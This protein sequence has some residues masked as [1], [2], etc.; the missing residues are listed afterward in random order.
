MKKYCLKNN[1]MKKTVL[2]G[3]LVFLFAQCN[4]VKKNN[5]HYD[6]LIPIEKLQEDID[7]TYKKLQQLH[8]NLYD[9]ITKPALDYKFDSLK[10]TITNPMKP[11]DFYKKISPIVAAVRQGHLYVYAPMILMTKKESKALLKKG[12]GPF[13]QF[14]FEYHNNKL[15]ILNNKSTD[16]TIQVG[17]EVIC[18]NGINTSDLVAE[19]SNYYASDGFN[20]TFKTRGN[21]DR[22][23]TF[24]TIEN[25]IKDSLV[26][27]LK[28]NDTIKNR[29]I[30][31]FKKETDEKKK[32]EVTKPKKIAIDHQKEKELRRKK[33]INGYN[34]ATKDYTRNIHFVEK[35]SSIAVIKIRGFKNRGYKKFYK[36]TFK[37]IKKYHSKNL[38]LD[39]RDNTGGRLNEINYLYSFLA[40]TA[41]IFLDKTQVVSKSSIIR[42]DYLDKVPFVIKA[43]KTIIFPLSYTYSFITTHK[44]KEG[45]YYQ[46]LM[47]REQKIKK[48]AF[49]SKIYVLINGKSFSASSILSSNLKG[50][51]RATFVGEETG[52]DYNGTVAGI[53]PNVKL[54]NSDLKIRIGLMHIVPHY[55]TATIG[56]GIYPD[57]EIIP[58]IED[59]INKNDTELNWIL[60]DIKDTINTK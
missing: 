18:V 23:T 39:L 50:S 38:I 19:Y 33:R 44:D 25:G 35:D 58:T 34:Q 13:S 16:S 21:K 40:D 55:K 2:L 36:E 26:Y 24:F 59:L 46:K 31:R 47:S 20:T 43:L 37:K 22:F 57:K 41:Y 5:A 7:F 45:Y 17:S 14:D 29:T 53:M 42:G 15:Y 9:Y 48:N 6:A 11:L 30:K 56:H 32:E 54:P 51:N 8:P 52:G 12:I 49:T 60:N 27:T 28:Y 1:E 3:F 10:T 4:S